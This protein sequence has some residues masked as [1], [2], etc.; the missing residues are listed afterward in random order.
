MVLR[1]ADELRAEVDDLAA[2]DRLVEHPP[3]DAVARLEHRDRVPG[4]RDL[5]R[6]DEPGQA[7]ADDD[8]VLAAAHAAPAR[9]PLRGLGG[10]RAA[11]ARGRGRGGRRGTGDEAAAADASVVAHACTITAPG[12]ACQTADVHETAA[13]NAALRPCARPV[14]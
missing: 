3:A 9:A 12:R 7:G 14:P 6:R 8:D 2:G 10:R 13:R 1:R 4:A 11:A 5:A